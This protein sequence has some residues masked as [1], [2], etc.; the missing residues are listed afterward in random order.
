MY[1]DGIDIPYNLLQQNFEKSYGKEYYDKYSS[2][3]KT[4]FAAHDEANTG[5]NLHNILRGTVDDPTRFSE[6]AFSIDNLLE[7][8]QTNGLTFLATG[9]LDSLTIPIRKALQNTGKWIN[10]LYPLLMTNI[11]NLQGFIS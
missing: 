4:H 2:G 11:L 3:L 5:T 6:E 10:T 1:D 8:V 7:R 9:N